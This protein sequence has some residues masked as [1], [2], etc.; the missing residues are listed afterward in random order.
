MSTHLVVQTGWYWDAEFVG[1]FVAVNEGLDSDL[2]IGVT[3]LEGGAG[4]TPEEMV[5]NGTVH[6]AITVRDTTMRLIEAGADLEVIGAQYPRDPLA[7]LVPVAS[8]VWSLHDLTGRR[9]AVPD[10]SK[11]GLQQGL[12]RAGVDPSSVPTSAYDGSAEPLTSGEVDGVVGYVTT[13]PLDLADAGVPTRSILL[14][15]QD[16]DSFRQ[17]LIVARRSRSAQEAEAIDAW[18]QASAEGWRRNT[19]DPSHY[20]RE[21]RTTWFARTTRSLEDE[22]THNTRQLEFMGDPESY[23]CT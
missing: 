11:D 20:P 6:V 23:L 13:L 8:P 3:F 5:L 14:S 9:V 7:V 10:V 4:I 15:P 18:L 16:D 2:G 12:A 21:L 17:N 19:K 22:I 1:Y